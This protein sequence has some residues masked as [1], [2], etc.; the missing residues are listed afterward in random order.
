MRFVVAVL[1]TARLASVALVLL[2][3]ARLTAKFE[4]V[5]RKTVLLLLVLLYGGSHGLAR[6]R[7]SLPHRGPGARSTRPW[8]T[9]LV[10]CSES[11][12][13]SRAARI[14]CASWFHLVFY[15]L[16]LA[17]IT[18]ISLL[19]AWRNW[20]WILP[21]RGTEQRPRKAESARQQ[22]Q[23]PAGQPM[24]REPQ[25]PQ[26]DLLADA[27]YLADSQHSREIIQT[28]YLLANQVSSSLE[29]DV[30]LDSI[31]TTLQQV[32]ACRGSVIFLLDQNK[33]WLEMCASCGVKPHWQQHA[34]MR[35]GEGISGKAVQEARPFYIPD[36]QLD[37][38][39]IVFDPNVRSLLVVPLVHKGEVIGTLNVDDT[40]PDAFSGDVSRLLSIAGAQV[41]AA[42][43]NARLY[44]DLKER[45]EHLA[46]AHRELQESER[47]KSEFV[48]NMSHELR[49]PLTFIK[50]YVEILQAGTLGTLSS[51]Q[52][53]SLQIVADWTEK[54]VHLVDSLLTI[55]QIERQDLEFA[56][57]DLAAL[58]RDAVHS[59]QARAAQAG[60]EFVLEI[61]AG[62][63]PRMGR[64]RAPGSSLGQPD[65]QRDQ[66]QPRRRHD[67]RPSRLREKAHRTKRFVRCAVIDQGIGI[68]PDQPSAR[69]W[70]LLP[71]R[72][73]QHAPLWGHRAWIGHRQR[74]RRG[75]R[76]H[77]DR[78]ERA[79]SGKPL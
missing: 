15:Y 11:K 31:V 9:T 28:L 65:R 37:P 42:I 53:E 5:T 69:F 8:S 17:I 52:Q 44:Q 60:I 77:G 79:G 39:F 56:S 4:A 20:G 48:Q 7:L 63:A 51:P 64:Q 34:R 66:V 75:A 24:N 49:T 41:A 27:K 36:T 30:V 58:A 71:G 25:V 78:P 72:W 14:N 50:A 57:L 55:Q 38:D 2:I 43:V 35:V 76:R 16:P 22:R 18:T 13:G 74:D 10:S 70:P 54:L 33:E 21:T 47:L 19:L 23:A 40:E 62:P 32:L 12:S 6:R 1:S 3:L 73:F 68:A 45:A 67:H 26:Q 46:Q 61:R 59:A 29:L